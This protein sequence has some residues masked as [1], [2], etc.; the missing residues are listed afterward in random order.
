MAFP[1]CPKCERTV[2]QD[3][4]YCPSCGYKLKSNK[5]N[6][7]WIGLFLIIF[8][9][10]SVIL[11]I[12][13]QTTQSTQPPANQSPQSTAKQATQPSSIEKKWY[14]GGT[15]HRATIA[16]WR[17]ATDEN[18]LATCSDFIALT[19]KEK[20][21]AYNETEILAES[22]ALKKCIDEANKGVDISNWKVVDIAA[23]CL[24]LLGYK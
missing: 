17:L 23:P 20:G 13:N 9:L 2:S 3:A 21:K 7:V 14:E 19:R 11:M 18:K 6:A 12:S 5:S 10:G 4:L 15:L 24:I 8:A 1:N 22:Y 16:D